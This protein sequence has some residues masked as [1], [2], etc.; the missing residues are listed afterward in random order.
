MYA[1]ISAFMLQS[2]RLHILITIIRARSE[3]NSR[4]FDEK[5]LRL[6]QRRMDSRSKN[7]T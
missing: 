6:R 4:T 7:Y 3:L 1:G 5:K 2:E